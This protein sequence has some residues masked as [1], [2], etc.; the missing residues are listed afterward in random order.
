[1]RRC[2]RL[3]PH[4]QRC[5]PP[6]PG[7]SPTSQHL[8]KR[9]PRRGYRCLFFGNHSMSGVVWVCVADKP[10]RVIPGVDPGETAERGHLSYPRLLQHAKPRCIHLHPHAQP[11]RIVPPLLRPSSTSANV[12][13][14]LGVDIL[15]C[16]KLS[17]KS[18]VLCCA[19]LQPQI[20]IRG[21]NPGVVNS[22]VVNLEVNL[23]V[24]RVVIREVNWALNR[25]PR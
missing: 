14:R 4:S 11:Y 12:Y 6:L 2:I 24:T 21:G 3:H 10:R 8:R 23:V 16:W 1:M 25:G 17:R 13:N 5:V 19:A 22:G 15:V 20:F 9:V 7:P 18:G